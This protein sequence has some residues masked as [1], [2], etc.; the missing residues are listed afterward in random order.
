MNPELEKFAPVF[1]EL[2]FSQEDWYLVSPFFTNI[3]ASVYGVSMLPPE[4]I[5]ALCSRASRAKDDLRLAM[6]NEYIK[7]FLQDEGEYSKSMKALIEFLHQYPAE[8][9]F[10]NPKARDF[11]IK[12]L[13]Q[14]GDDSIAQMAGTH[15]VYTGISQLT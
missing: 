15:L 12:W 13:A 11:Y 1:E 6:L 5:G 2:G 10:A 7:P 9:I 4:V 14:F 3:N 8:K